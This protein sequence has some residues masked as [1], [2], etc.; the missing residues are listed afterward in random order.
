MFD[1]R[2]MIK[3]KQHRHLDILKKILYL[4]TFKNKRKKIIC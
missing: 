4:K 2:A 1:T 3:R